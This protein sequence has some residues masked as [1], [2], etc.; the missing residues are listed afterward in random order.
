MSNEPVQN[1]Q[2]KEVDQEMVD[3]AT[4]IQETLEE[5]GMAISPFLRMGQNGITPDA[6]IVRTNQETDEG[7]SEPSGEVAEEPASENTDES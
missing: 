2:T 3:V 5:H 7:N 1:A 6:R 4:K